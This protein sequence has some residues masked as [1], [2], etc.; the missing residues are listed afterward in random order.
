MMSKTILG[1]QAKTLL[2]TIARNAIVQKL[3]LPEMAVPP[4]LPA[5]LTASGASFV[6]LTQESDGQ[7]R[8][9]MGSLTSNQPLYRNVQ[10]NAYLAAFEDPRF[11]PVRREEWVGLAIEVSVLSKPVLLGPKEPAEL[12]AYLQQRQPGVVLERPPYRATFL[13]DVW[14]QLPDARKF[15]EALT[16]K[17][18]I[19]EADG[20]K[21]AH[22]LTYR[23]T[24][25][26]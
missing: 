9:C 26:R 24:I 21:S 3:G 1:S 14:N 2:L 22:F 11:P 23:T 17:A 13:P 25:I 15:L 8:G 19:K 10:S 16:K 18:G 7:L 12:L 6:T 20:W 4:D 5:K